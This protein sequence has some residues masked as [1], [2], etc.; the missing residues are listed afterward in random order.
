MTINYMIRYKNGA[1][2]RILLYLLPSKMF[3]W[4]TLNLC[5][6]LTIFF[7]NFLDLMLTPTIQPAEATTSINTRATTATMQTTSAGNL[8]QLH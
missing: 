5:K 1:R 2:D 7:Y 6:V 8:H 4:P 3:T